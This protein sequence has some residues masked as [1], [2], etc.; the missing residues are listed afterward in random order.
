[1]KSSI[2]VILRN[3]QKFIQES[4]SSKNAKISARKQ[5]QKQELLMQNL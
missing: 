3:C 5:A 1:M 4:R 2:D